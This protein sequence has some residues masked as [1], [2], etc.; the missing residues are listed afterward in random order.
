M[1]HLEGLGIDEQV[2][3]EWILQKYDA[4]VWMCSTGSG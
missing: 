4:R 3:L 2:R 1:Y